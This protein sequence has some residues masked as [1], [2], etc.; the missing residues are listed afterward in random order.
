MDRIWNVLYVI[1]AM[2][3]VWIVAKQRR[4]YTM[5]VLNAAAVPD[6]HRQRLQHHNVD[7]AFVEVYAYFNFFFG[8]NYNHQ[9]MTRL[10]IHSTLITCGIKGTYLVAVTTLLLTTVLGT[11]V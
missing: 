7:A 1:T 3:L 4:I 11:W 6:R 10:D 2:S 8:R 5:V 9:T